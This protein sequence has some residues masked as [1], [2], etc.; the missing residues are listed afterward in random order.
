MRRWSVIVLAILVSI[1]LAACGGDSGSGKR[2]KRSTTTTSSTTTSSSTTSS[3]TSTTTTTAPD[4][5]C[6]VSQL[7][8]QLTEGSPGAGQRYATLVFT[9]NGGQPCTMLGFIGMQLR[10]MGG[11][12]L[13]TNV[14][15]NS[16]VPSSTVTLAPGAKAFTVLHW[17]AVASGNEPTNGPCQPTPNQ[18]QITPPNNTS[19]LVQPWTFGEVCQ[20]GQIDVN[21]MQAGTGP[22]P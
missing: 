15:R 20:Q 10:G 3:T 11:A 17:G 5:T 12:T 18:V 19:F 16:S 14:V 21:A 9:N 4:T 22:P 6:Q 7:A 13:P 2:K 1:A 8:A